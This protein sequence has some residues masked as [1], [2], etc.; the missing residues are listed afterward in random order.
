MDREAAYRRRWTILGVLVVS[1]LVVVLDNTILN[2]AL[3]T[4]QIEL[5]ATNSQLIWAVNSYS[6]VFASLLF[7]WGVLG[8]RFGRKRVLVVGM[9]LFGVASAFSAFAA[10][11][12][13][14]I[15]YRALMGI[16][17]AAVLPVTLAIITNVFPPDERGKA[18]GAWAGAVGIAVAIGPITGGFLL[19]HFWWGS[20]FL[21]NVPVVIIGVLGIV[22]L[23][24]ESKGGQRARIDP[25]GVVMSVAGL[26]MLVYGIVHGGDTRQ[27]GSPDVWGFI[28]GGVAVLALFVWFES[29]SDHPSLDVRLFDNREFSTTLAAVTTAF[30]GLMGAT[31]FLVFYLQLVR[32]MSPL[33]AGTALL[34]LA[35]GQFFAATRSSKTAARFGPRVVIG[36]GLVLV[37]LVFAAMVLVDG[38]TPLWQVLTLYLLIGVGMG[39]AIAPATTVMMSTLPLERAGAGSA[40]QNTVRQVGGA[41]GVAIT[42][43]VIAVVFGAQLEKAGAGLP[44]TALAQASD[45]LGAAYEVVQAATAK[46]LLS[47]DAA[48]SA[49]AVAND[50]FI[51]AMHVATLLTAAAALLGGLVA[52]RFLPNRADAARIAAERQRQFTEREN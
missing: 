11:P 8:D 12:E 35:F 44:P 42:G 17:G 10:S 15:V 46:G 37:S 26:M 2:V 18:I 22:V 27:W 29:R 20:V 36:S 13:Q 41:L 4:I 14:L 34:P 33:Q 45:S 32:G 16:G 31:F 1:L 43:T 25:V 39:S 48:A 28:V 51:T 9:L 19:E 30:F 5:G 21:I 23:V 6:L 3:K 47:P 52:Y 49:I 38:E 24:P 50:S 7:T 40:V